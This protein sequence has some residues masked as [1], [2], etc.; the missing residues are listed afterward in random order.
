META[1]ELIAREKEARAKEKQP[2]QVR[3]PM[4]NLVAMNVRDC[5]ESA[6]S[7]RSL[8]KLPRFNSLEVA[9]FIA[10]LVVLGSLALR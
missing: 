3:L 9:M 5:T 6:R 10:L 2:K 8:P 1:A 4:A 7:I